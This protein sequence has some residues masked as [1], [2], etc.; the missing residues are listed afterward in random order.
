M[1]QVYKNG[2]ENDNKL[3]DGR[4]AAVEDR[5]LGVRRQGREV[6]PELEWLLQR[7][8]RRRREEWSDR[9]VGVGRLH[10]CADGR[11][12]PAWPQHQRRRNPGRGL[13]VVHERIP[14]QRPGRASLSRTRSSM[15][16][17]TP[18]TRSSVRRRPR[19]RLRHPRRTPATSRRSASPE[20]AEVAAEAAAAAA[21]VAAEV[22]AAGR[23]SHRR[24]HRPAERPP[25]HRARRAVAAPAVA[26]P[27]P[28]PR[29]TLTVGRPGSRSADRTWVGVPVAAGCSGDDFRPCAGRRLRP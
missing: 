18:A 27:A 8:H 6:G 10:R 5:H 15:V 21:A 19:H 29:T 4:E 20:A 12:R 28:R 11:R 2:D 14:E 22:A 16:S 17:R 1:Q 7:I 13:G 25:R 24:R 3:D 9:D 26:D 23:P